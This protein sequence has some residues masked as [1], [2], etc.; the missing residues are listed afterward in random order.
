MDWKI[1]SLECYPEYEG[2]ENVVF[3]AHW[4]I[5]H[6]EDGFSGYAY[7]SAGLTLDPEAEFV[8]FDALSEDTVVGWVKDALGEDQ[9]AAHEASVTKQIDDQKN[10]PIVR[11]DLPWA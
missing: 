1:V 2:Q 4:N 6:E 10:P 7:G 5:T 3:T 9:V 11:L 8:A